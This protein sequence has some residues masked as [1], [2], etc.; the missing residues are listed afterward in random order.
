[1][2]LIVSKY[3]NFVPREVKL[4]AAL[5]ERNVDVGVKSKCNHENEN[6]RFTMSSFSNDDTV[7]ITIVW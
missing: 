3:C 7:I 5:K 4:D 1:M 6:N 2:L